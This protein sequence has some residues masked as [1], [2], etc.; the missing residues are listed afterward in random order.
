MKKNQ[1][2]FAQK[3]KVIAEMLL[4][5]KGLFTL[6]FSFYHLVNIINVA[7]PTQGTGR[8]ILF[9]ISFFLLLMLRNF[10]KQGAKGLGLGVVLK[11]EKCM[12]SK[13]ISNG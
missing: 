7:Y 6:I 13:K 11:K 3:L 5:W 4:H 1:C 8:S 10:H 9:F 12:R 2:R